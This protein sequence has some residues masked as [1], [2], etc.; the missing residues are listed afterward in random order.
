MKIPTFK[1]KAEVWLF[2]GPTAWHFVSLAKALSEQIR[3]H[4]AEKI[5]GWG[6]VRIRASIGKTTWDTSVFPEKKSG[7]YILPLKASVRKAEGIKENDTIRVK[8]E[9]I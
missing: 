7:C 9:I 8:L 4:A 2:Q 5:A 6:S 1:F 3:F